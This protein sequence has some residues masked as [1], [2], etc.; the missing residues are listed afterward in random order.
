MF[1]EKL[2]TT[3][4]NVSCGLEPRLGTG[5]FTRLFGESKTVNDGMVLEPEV[6]SAGFQLYEF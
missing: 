6:L 5:N 3:E 1:P 2:P 4:I